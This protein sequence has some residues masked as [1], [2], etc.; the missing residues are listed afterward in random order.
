MVY[1][2]CKRRV[3]TRRKGPGRMHLDHVVPWSQG[4]THS[5]E[6]LV[7]SCAKC[8]LAKSDDASIVP[9]GGAV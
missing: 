3:H 1:R 6:N 5:V 8:N 2:Y 7:V 9:V 4:G